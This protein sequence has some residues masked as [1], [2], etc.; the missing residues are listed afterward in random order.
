M[1]RFSTGA[2]IAEHDAPMDLDVVCIEGK[3]FVSVGDG[4]FPSRAD[5]SVLWPAGTM[6]RL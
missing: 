4:S 3:G 5:D 1:L 2:T 6:H